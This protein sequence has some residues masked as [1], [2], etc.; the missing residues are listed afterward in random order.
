MLDHFKGLEKQAKNGDFNNYLGIQ[1]SITEAWNKTK[2]YYVKTD[3]SV[4]W[5]TAL[6]L[7]PRF[8]FEFFEDV[9]KDTPRFVTSSRAKFKKLWTDQYRP[10]MGRVEQSPDPEQEKVSYLESVLNK[11]SRTVQ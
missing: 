11:W 9:W 7:H 4:T 2:D 3:I 10:E 8:K 5:V 6:V 1:N